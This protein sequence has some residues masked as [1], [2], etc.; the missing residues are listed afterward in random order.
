MYQHV[1]IDASKAAP[2][3]LP[4]CST[5]LVTLAKLAVAKFES[6]SALNSIRI[7]RFE[8]G[9]MFL[10]HISQSLFIT[11]RSPRRL[12]HASGI[13]RRE[14]LTIS[15]IFAYYEARCLVKFGRGSQGSYCCG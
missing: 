11:H 7:G 12:R 9:P 10:K 4:K 15:R 6:D 8:G 1:S 13:S 3:N 14:R 2:G 5:D